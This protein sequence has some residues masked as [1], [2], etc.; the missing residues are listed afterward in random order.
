MG[1]RTEDIGKKYMIFKA[2]KTDG[3]V[4]EREKGAKK[5]RTRE[6]PKDYLLP[7]CPRPPNPNTPAPTLGVFWPNFS[8]HVRP[9]DDSEKPL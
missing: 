2:V 6:G 3:D 1:M 7:L 4:R 9:G 8:F 5:Q